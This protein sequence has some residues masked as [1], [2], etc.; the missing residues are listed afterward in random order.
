MMRPAPVAGHGIAP[1]PQVALEASAP[2]AQI[3]ERAIMLAIA[4]HTAPATKPALSATDLRADLALDKQLG[5]LTDAIAEGNGAMPLLVRKM[6]DAQRRRDAVAALLA[7]FRP[8][9][10][11]S[12][13]TSAASW[14]RASA[15]GKRSCGGT[16]P[17]AVSSCGSCLSGAC[18]SRAPP[19]ASASRAT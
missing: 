2:N 11:L 3:V 10:S 14:R 18:A 8:P 12:T 7:P 9:R 13:R 19:R 17:R 16:C 6:Q 4:E 15:T 1:D 5:N